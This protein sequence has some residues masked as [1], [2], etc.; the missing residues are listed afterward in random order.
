MFKL[1]LEACLVAFVGG[2][3][4]VLLFVP[5]GPHRD[6][7]P[8]VFKQK[9]AHDQSIL[10]AEACTDFY[11]AVGRFPSK[12]AELLDGRGIPGWGGPYLDPPQLPND[13]WG[14]PYGYEPPDVAG[15]KPNVFS[16]GA[17]GVPGGLGEDQDLHTKK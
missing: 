17:D 4:Y 7:P 8:E 1:V 11:L 13:P 3:V 6:Y 16:L 15:G 10:L 14:R 9:K 5:A 2:C 12:L